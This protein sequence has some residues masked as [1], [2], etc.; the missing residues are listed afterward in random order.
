[1]TALIESV[2][3]LVCSLTWKRGLVSALT[4]A[5]FRSQLSSTTTTSHLLHLLFFPIFSFSLLSFI[6]DFLL[7]FYKCS[8]SCG[9]DFFFLFIE[10]DYCLLEASED[11]QFTSLFPRK[12]WSAL[13]ILT[14]KIL[15]RREEEKRCIAS[16]DVFYII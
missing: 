12:L 11:L 15:L 7:F 16:F 10:E 14:L 9:E 8:P 4:L 3:T 13:K 2:L 6:E 5:S 1:M